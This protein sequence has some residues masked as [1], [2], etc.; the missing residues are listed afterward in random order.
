MNRNQKIILMVGLFLI[1]LSGIFPAYEGEWRRTGDNLK[2]N[3]G[4]NFIFAPPNSIKVAKAF[5]EYVERKYE[6]S[7]YLEFNA[8][9]ISSRFFIQIV[10][11]LIL[12]IGLIYLFKDFNFK[13]KPIVFKKNQL[14]NILLAILTILVLGSF[15]YFIVSRI[16][17]NT[18]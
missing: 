3:L 17:A 13:F 7:D 18:R 16:I 2:V 14:R 1:L 5:N 10:T 9:I 12:T 15:I 6:I 11:I 8:T 4:Y